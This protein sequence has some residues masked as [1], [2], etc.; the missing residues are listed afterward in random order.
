MLRKQRL[1]L[2]FS[3]SGISHRIL[4]AERYLSAIEEGNWQYLP[5]EIYIRNFLKRYAEELKLDPDRVIKAYEKKQ[6]Q[7][8]ESSIGS[9][10]RTLPL[11]TTHF[12]MLPKI[13]RNILLGFAGIAVVGYLL[14]QVNQIIS[15]P[16]LEIYT[17]ADNFV[18][19]ATFV[20]V[21]GKTDMGVELTINDT[22][23][24]LNQ[25]EFEEVVDLQKGLNI[26]KI[27]AQKKYSKATV[28]ERKIM[29]QLQ[30]VTKN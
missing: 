9:L 22:V 26:I 4:V 1:Q 23:V 2:G 30:D 27:T 28:K 10:Q 24:N 16:Y 14:F 21:S 20:V 19:E 11:P 8:Y 17:P 25:G 13:L 5:G 29:S 12:L 6:D 7:A 3:L 15:P 18:T